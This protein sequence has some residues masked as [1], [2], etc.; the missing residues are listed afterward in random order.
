MRARRGPQLAVDAPDCDHVGLVWEAARRRT[1]EYDEVWCVLDTELS[2]GLVSRLL[3]AA[4][5][6]DVRLALSSP[7][8]EF[9]LILHLD[10]HTRPFQ[11]AKEAKQRLN[12]LLPGWSEAGTRYPDFAAGVRSACDRARRLQPDDGERPRN[13]SSTA[14]RLVEKIIGSPP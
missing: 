5:R 10:D 14:W 1:G 6:A 13:P 12:A 7:C 11:S 2:D 4:R 3:D 9:W 8:F